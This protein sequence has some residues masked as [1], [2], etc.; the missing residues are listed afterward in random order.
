[1]VKNNFSEETFTKIRS[2]LQIVTFWVILRADKTDS[3][4][5]PNS[6][7]QQRS[8]ISFGPFR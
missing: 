5:A 4:Y 1:M 7:V 6:F 2:Q 3:D 8:Y